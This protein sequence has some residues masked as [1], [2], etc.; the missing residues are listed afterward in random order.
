MAKIYVGRFTTVHD[1]LFCAHTLCMNYVT[2][3]FLLVSC[4]NTRKHLLYFVRF[5]ARSRPKKPTKTYKKNFAGI[6]N[7]FALL[8]MLQ[9]SKEYIVSSATSM[10]NHQVRAILGQFFLLSTGVS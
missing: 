4:L 2:E 10:K 1:L 7:H 8:N 6:R 5:C 9:P 3:T